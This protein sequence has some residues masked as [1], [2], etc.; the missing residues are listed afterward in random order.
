[1]AGAGEWGMKVVHLGW[2]NR[3]AVSGQSDESTNRGNLLSLQVVS[4]EWT[5]LRVGWVRNLHLRKRI[6]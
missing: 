6:H 4:P 2:S 3:H 5:A 1:M